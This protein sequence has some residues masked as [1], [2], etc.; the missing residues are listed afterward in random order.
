MDKRVSDDE[1]GLHFVS[2]EVPQ[3]V[4]SM[5]RQCLEQADYDRDTAVDLLARK[6]T[7]DRATQTW[8]NTRF[9]RAII[10]LQLRNEL[11]KARTVAT[12]VDE[13]PPTK[14]TFAYTP[15]TGGSTLVR[16]LMGQ[17][18]NEVGKRLMDCSA[19]DLDKLIEVNQTRVTTFGINLAFYSKV[20]EGLEDGKTVAQC[21]APDR[22][23]AMWKKCVKKA[24]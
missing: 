3:S 15:Q 7:S 24:A 16:G 9:A 8:V 17:F 4:S 18:I 12:S 5:I 22:I 14:R 6:F 20:R 11:A 19:A 23:D 10:G 2:F 1:G 13:E 21:Y